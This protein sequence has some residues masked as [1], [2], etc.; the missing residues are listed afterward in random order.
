MRNLPFH[1]F[2]ANQIWLEVVSLAAELLTWM[3]TLAFD[4]RQP[5][6]RWEP[7]RLRLRLLAVAGRIIHTGRRRHLRLPR[8]WPWTHLIHTG[9][10]ALHTA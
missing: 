5:V 3:Q 1:G 8:D 7:A 4:Q 6:R 10:T 2:D 9:W